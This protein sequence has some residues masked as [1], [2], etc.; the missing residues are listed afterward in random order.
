MEPVLRVSPMKTPTALTAALA[1]LV[2]AGALHVSSP[3]DAQSLATP[4]Y[5]AAQAA[6]GKAAFE[7]SCASCHGTNL[8]DGEF[9]PPLRGNDFRLRWGA[10]PLD[11]LFDEMSRT[12]P[13]AAPNTL[14]DAVY[15]Q[16]LAY[17]AQENG[18]TAGTRELTPDAAALARGDAAGRR[19]W[20][21]RR[22]DDR[23]GDSAAA[24]AGQ[25]ARPADRRHRR[26]ADDP[27][28]RRVADLAALVR[29]PGLQPADA[30]QQAERRR[31]A[32]GLELGAAERAQRGHAARARRRDVRARLRRQGAGASTRPPATCCGSTRGACR[33]IA[34][35]R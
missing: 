18:V 14:G 2:F 30:D 35:R 7:R 28:R 16:L 26:H 31:P 1:A 32:A 21:Q 8:D 27:R 34:R 6:Q 24:A 17:L 9:A 22:P 33:G 12:M 11:T 20:T 3:L 23:R 15:A 19:R 13:P 10:K 5:T 4:N 25:P 29:Q